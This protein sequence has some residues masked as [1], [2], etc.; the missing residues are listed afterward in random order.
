MALYMLST[1]IAVCLIRGTSR[2]LDERV[3]S[4]PPEELCI[5]AVTRGELLLGVSRQRPLAMGDEPTPEERAR[6]DLSQGIAGEAFRRVAEAQAVASPIGPATMESLR[7]T[8]HAVLEKLTP[9]EAK[10]LRMRF[11]IDPSTDHTLEKISKQFEVTRERIRSSEA[12]R[13]REPEHDLSRVVDQFLARVSCLPWDAA[14]AT[15]FATIAVELH[16][17][18]TPMGTTDTMVAGH[19]IAVGAVLVA[20]NEN[21]FPRVG[22]L[23]TENWMRRRTSQ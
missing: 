10:A 23:K 18:G 2:T 19:A 16:R 17:I 11:G 12:V 9:H 21:R 3:A 8:T 14:A 7:K 20:S 4:A 22:G 1:D 6:G 15:H 13:S 5:S